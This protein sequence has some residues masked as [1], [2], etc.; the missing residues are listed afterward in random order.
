MRLRLGLLGTRI[1]V[2]FDPDHRQDDNRC[3]FI[4]PVTAESHNAPLVRKF[5]NDAHQPLST[6]AGKEALCLDA[7]KSAS[8]QLS[9]MQG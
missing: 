9:G 1:G 8:L 7:R 2:T 3:G 4:R 5:D 6:A